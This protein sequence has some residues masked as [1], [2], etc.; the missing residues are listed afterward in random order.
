M[1][2]GLEIHIERRSETASDASYAFWVKPGNGGALVPGSTGAS[3]LVRLSKLSGEVV[4][5]QPCPDDPD[6]KLNLHLRVAAKLRSH[7]SNGEYPSSTGW[8]A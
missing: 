8:A 1:S 3:G 2:I 7:W 6:A 5:V 4:L